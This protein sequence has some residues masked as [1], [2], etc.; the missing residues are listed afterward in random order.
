MAWWEW[1]HNIHHYMTKSSVRYPELS[2]VDIFDPRPDFHAS[3]ACF[4][5]ILYVDLYGRPVKFLT[6]PVKGTFD[7]FMVH[8]M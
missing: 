2:L 1:A 7:P 8:L 3:I 6:N 4:Y 5:V